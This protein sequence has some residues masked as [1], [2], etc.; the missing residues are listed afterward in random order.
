M[1]R[2]AETQPSSLSHTKRKPSCHDS[3]GHLR[4]FGAQTIARF[5]VCM[6]VTELKVARRDRCLMRNSRVLW[7][8]S[9]VNVIV[10][11]FKYFY[12][13]GKEMDFSN[14]GGR[15]LW[16]K[17]K[18]ES[19]FQ[20]SEIL[21]HLGIQAG[22]LAQISETYIFQNKYLR[23]KQK[24]IFLNTATFRSLFFLWFLT[25]IAIKLL[26]FPNLGETGK[27]RSH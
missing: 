26:K 23:G 2:T 13:N 18:S 12:Q 11:T 17:P 5:F 14:W 22:I 6:L 1:H 24:S 25:W 15:F 21:F 8:T 4:R 19:I 10:I 7:I 16:C 27:R 9:K 3:T 20:I